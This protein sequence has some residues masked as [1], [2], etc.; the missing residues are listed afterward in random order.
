M[1]VASSQEAR[2]L[3]STLLLLLSLASAFWVRGLCVLKH[4]DHH[5]AL[6][7][8][9]IDKVHD[10]MACTDAARSATSLGSSPQAIQEE[11]GASPE[12]ESSEEVREEPGSRTESSDQGLEKPPA[13]TAEEVEKVCP[14][15]SAEF[16]DPLL[17]LLPHLEDGHTNI[18][19][20]GERY[21][22]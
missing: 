8:M 5:D 1:H 3:S 11:S 10:D 22:P 4:A 16:A 18:L 21:C 6:R 13:Q 20:V 12:V 17:E 19:H 2:G 7:M 15:H 14:F 9:V